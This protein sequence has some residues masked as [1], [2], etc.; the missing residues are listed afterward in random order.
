MKKE[1][2]TIDFS[3]GRKGGGTNKHRGSDAEVPDVTNV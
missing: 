2:K 1:I 3:R